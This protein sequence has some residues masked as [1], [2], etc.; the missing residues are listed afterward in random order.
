MQ[1]YAGKEISHACYPPIQLS[2]EGD[3]LLF[4]EGQLMLTAE[5]PSKVKYII[6]NF[7][8]NQIIQGKSVEAE[9]KED[10]QTL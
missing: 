3:L 2:L 8:K 4:Q 5:T 1:T 9:E 10:E 6:I 7:F